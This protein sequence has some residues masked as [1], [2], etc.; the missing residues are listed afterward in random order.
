MGSYTLSMKSVQVDSSE[1]GAISSGSDEVRQL[2]QVLQD[3]E[4]IFQPPV[5]LPPQRDI[6]HIIELKDGTQPFS[7]RPY[8]NSFEQKNEIEKLV[9]KTLESG[10]G[11][12]VH[13]LLLL[14]C[15]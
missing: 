3:Y 7:I 10:I 13:L 14:F 2:Q 11:Q 12:V 5:G 6:E 1:E 4:D 8:R 9:T 15:W